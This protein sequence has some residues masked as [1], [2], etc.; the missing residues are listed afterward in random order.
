MPEV[1][2]IL[3]A[4]GLSRRMGDKNK[5]LLPIGGIPMVRHVA[6]TYLDAIDGHLVVVTGFQSDAVERALGGLDVQLVH[7]AAFRSGQSWSVATGLAHAPDTDLLLIGLADQPL[8]TPADLLDLIRAHRNAD[9]HRITIPMQSN[10]RGNPIV[11]PRTLRSRLMENQDRPGCMRFTRDFPEHVQVAPLSAAGFY[12]DI[13][14]PE[15]FRALAVS[16]TEGA[17]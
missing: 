4:A 1:T 9:P 8:L 12:R 5:L 2:A 16:E 14:T 7:N 13:D 15:E 10:T 11:I 6:K 3:L 17:L